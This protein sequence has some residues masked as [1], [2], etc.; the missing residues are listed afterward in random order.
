[1]TSSIPIF[2]LLQW[3]SAIKL[4]AKGLK[5]SRG[6]VWAHAKKALNITGSREE[7]VNYITQLIEEYK[8]ENNID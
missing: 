4:E 2:Q 5:N 6:S 3:R 7:V 1:M 8:D